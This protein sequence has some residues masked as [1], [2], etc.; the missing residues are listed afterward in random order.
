MILWEITHRPLLRIT[1]PRSRELGARYPYPGVTDGGQSFVC[2]Q[3]PAGPIPRPWKKPSGTEVQ[4][5]ASW[6]TPDW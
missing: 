2:R 3:W 5:P 4:M 1:S 6:K